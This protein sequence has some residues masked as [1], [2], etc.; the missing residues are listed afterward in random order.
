MEDNRRNILIA[1]DNES[2]YLLLKT[3]LQK[4]YNLTWVINGKEALKKVR[5]QA[6]DLVLMDVK[7]PEM[8]GIEALKEIRKID[9]DLPVVMQTAY[10]F[11]SEKQEAIIA[12]CSSFITKPIM[13]PNL[14]TELRNIL[15]E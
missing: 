8:N 9:K 13:A 2:N 12:G 11:E 4:H 3:I 5:E 1:E 6:F 15:K 14:L 7:M 10:T